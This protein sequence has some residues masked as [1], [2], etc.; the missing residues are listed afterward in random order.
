MYFIPV[1]HR[2][3]PTAFRRRA[4]D[5]QFTC[6]MA[7]KAFKAEVRC[8]SAYFTLLSNYI[9]WMLGFAVRAILCLSQPVLI[10]ILR[11]VPRVGLVCLHTFVAESLRVTRLY[12]VARTSCIMSM[13]L[14]LFCRQY[15]IHHVCHSLAYICHAGRILPCLYETC[16]EAAFPCC[17]V[18]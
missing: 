10:R 13:Y 2:R 4:V 3:K 17:C 15:L 18:S 7:L 8:T 12:S 16:C 5:L 14:V 9:T 1:Y 6:G 11:H